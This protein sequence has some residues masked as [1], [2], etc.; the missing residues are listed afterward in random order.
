MTTPDRQTPLNDIQKADVLLVPTGH[1]DEGGDTV[2]IANKTG[3]NVVTTWEMAGGAVKGKIP[4]PQFVRTQPGSAGT[5][6]GIKIRVVNAVPGTGGA[7]ALSGGPALGVFITF[8]NHSTRY[9]R[10]SI[11]FTMA[12]QR[13]GS[14]FKPAAAILY[15]SAALDPTDGAYMARLLSTDNPN[16][17]T[18]IPHHHR[19]NPPPG[20]SPASLGEALRKLGLP[21][22]LLNPEPGKVYMLSK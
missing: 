9:F 17:Q 10:G 4:D 14:L 19:V 6:D 13:W 1:R 20:K 11:A 2:E 8:A 22:Q 12:M 7:N 16:V 5:V 18:I 21:V 3:A 15:Y